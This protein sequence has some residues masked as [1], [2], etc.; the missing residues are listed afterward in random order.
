MDEWKLFTL[1]V[2]LDSSIGN[3]LS[4][5]DQS[6]V[7]QGKPRLDVLWSRVHQLQGPSV[8][9][10]LLHQLEQAK[11]NYMEQL[12]L[13]LLLVELLI[14]VEIIWNSWSCCCCWLSC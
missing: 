11:G 9:V 3:I 13:L 5:A 1:Y 7:L 6:S 8:L 10:C 4:P 14:L 2:D 12:E